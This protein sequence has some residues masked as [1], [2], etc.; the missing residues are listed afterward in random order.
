LVDKGA[1]EYEKFQIKPGA[2]ATM[3]AY[4]EDLTKQIAAG[5]KA[6]TDRNE[7]YNAVMDYR[8]PNWTIAAFVRQGRVY[9]VLAKAVLNT[10][11]VVPADMKKTMAKLPDYAR[12]DVRIQVEDKVRQVLDTQT[13]PIECLAVYR[14][15]LAARAAKVG[16]IDNEYTQQA[17]SRL[18]AYGEERIAEC[19]AE[20][21]AKDNSV[22]AYQPGEFTRAPRGAVL[23]MPSGVSPPSL[24]EIR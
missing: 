18:G 12:E 23:P 22:Q 4:V 7:A 24:T 9:E 5:S 20:Q 11:F 1:E 17:I 13:R 2:P 10:P 3:N 6:A 8:R 15:A 19:I 14:Y 21:A 16:A